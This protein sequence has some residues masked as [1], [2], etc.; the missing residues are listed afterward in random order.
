MRT[1]ATESRR[2]AIARSETG[3][4]AGRPK[5][6]RLVGVR[7]VPVEIAAKLTAAAGTF[8]SSFDEVR[9][10]DIASAAGVSRTSLYYYFAG[11]D[12]ILAFLLRSMLEE[13]TQVVVSAADGTGSASMRLG[14][15]I[16]A[17]LEHLNAHPALSQMLIANLGRAGKLPDIAARVNDG[18]VDPVRRLLAEGAD[19]GSFR[20][21]PDDDLGAGALFG[22]V[23]VMGLRSLVAEGAID[24]DRVMAMVGPMFWHGIAP[25][26]EDPTPT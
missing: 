17:Q 25:R 21:L 6:V 1:T 15:V 2:V 14:A 20:K 16:R 8:V 18:F 12:D 13:L 10:E 4:P 9:M 5:A 23:L 3:S 22:A 26:S 24:V 7:E 11:K 19:D